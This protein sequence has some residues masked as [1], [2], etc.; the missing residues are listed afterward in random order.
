MEQLDKT[1]KFLV[2]LLFLAGATT[3]SL[4]HS[5]ECSKV[6][7]SGGSDYP[8]LHWYDGSK[9]TGASIE[10]ATTALKALKIPYEVRYAGPFYRALEGARNGEIDMLATLK[11]TLERRDFLSF[12]TP[13]PFTSPIAVF[14]LR[15]RPL[16]YR[17]WNDLIGK[18]GGVTL[19]YQF[20]DGFDDFLKEKLKVETEQKTYMNFSKLERGSIDYL[21]TGYYNGLAYLAESKQT[22]LFIAQMPFVTESKNYIAI[23]QKSPCI[24]YLKSINQQLEIMQNNGATKVI[25]DRHTKLL[26][27]NK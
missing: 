5:A 19:G 15:S 2:R 6:I 9:L 3:G 25:L 8:P 24:K 18:K 23:A 10:V 26:L 11:D 22:E 4:A 12:A 13:S 16:Q 27:N 21:I 1:T 7:I 14:T 20:G 17:A